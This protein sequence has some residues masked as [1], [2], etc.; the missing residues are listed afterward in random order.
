MTVGTVAAAM[1]SVVI[2]VVIVGGMGNLSDI[3]WLR[4]AYLA[5]LRC[6]GGVGG[7][8]SLPSPAP[9]QSGDEAAPDIMSPI[10]RV[11]IGPRFTIAELVVIAVVATCGC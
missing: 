3:S 5:R 6:I 9:R 2:V 1:S 11:T 4:D 7:G 10:P 8:L